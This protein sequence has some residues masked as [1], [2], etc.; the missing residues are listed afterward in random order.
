ML[1]PHVYNVPLLRI[2]KLFNPVDTVVQLVLPVEDMPLN[3][4]CGVT[5][6][7]PACVIV[8]PLL[9]LSI[10]VAFCAVNNETVPVDI[11]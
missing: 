3:G 6:G 5:A 11:P 4:L 8:N 9:E 10:I 7:V 2:A 1:S